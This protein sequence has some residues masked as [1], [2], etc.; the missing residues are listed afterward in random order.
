MLDDDHRLGYGDHCTETLRDGTAPGHVTVTVTIRRDHYDAADVSQH[1]WRGVR[2]R[3]DADL[4][5]FRHRSRT[6]SVQSDVVRDVPT[7]D[8]PAE[9]LAERLRAVGVGLVAGA[10]ADHVDQKFPGAVG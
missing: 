3:Q 2:R 5:A 1:A 8:H 9:D 4:A 6:V 7:A 10:F